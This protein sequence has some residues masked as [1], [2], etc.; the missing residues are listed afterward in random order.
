MMTHI[1]SNLT[2]EYENTVENLEDELD[3]DMLTFK[4][5]QDKL[6][7]NYDRMNGRSNQNEG[8]ES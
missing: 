8:K 3:N 6:S 5:I 7:S 4:I 1:I 2:E